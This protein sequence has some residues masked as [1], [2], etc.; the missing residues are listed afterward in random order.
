MTQKGT[1]SS[2]PPIIFPWEEEDLR[3]YYDYLNF[4]REKLLDVQ[5]S[6]RKPNGKMDKNFQATWTKVL[7]ERDKLFRRIYYNWIWADSKTLMKNASSNLKQLLQI[8]YRINFENMPNLLKPIQ[9][10]IKELDAR[11]NLLDDLEREQGI[12]RRKANFG[13]LTPTIT[14]KEIHDHPACANVQQEFFADQSK[15][16]VVIRDRLS[17]TPNRSSSNYLLLP[18]IQQQKLLQRSSSPPNYQSTSLTNI[19]H[20]KQ[21][22]PY[23]SEISVYES[24]VGS[25]DN[26][27][28]DLSMINDT[29]V[30]EKP[31]EFFV[32]KSSE[33]NLK[34]EKNFMKFG[35]FTSYGAFSNTK[36]Y[37]GVQKHSFGRRYSLRLNRASFD[38]L[39]VA[40]DDRRRRRL[41][42]QKRVPQMNVGLRGDFHYDDDSR[43]RRSGRFRN[44]VGGRFTRVGRIILQKR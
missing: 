20:N 43:R 7:T 37:Q 9:Q 13:G 15:R 41:G 2:H 10:M 28:T 30:V 14:V 29:T 23:C 6:F 8:S 34:T 33:N 31:I 5:E 39:A 27:Q 44:T 22:S 11:V 12:V 16:R 26:L 4:L 32:Q 38:D 17:S 21:K 24:A 3:N 25:F 35:Q 19:V 36:P 1:N 18:N 42:G 40:F